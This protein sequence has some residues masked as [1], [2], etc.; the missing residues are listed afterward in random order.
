[1]LSSPLAIFFS[2]FPYD[3]YINTHEF[4]SHDTCLFCPSFVLVDNDFWVVP[5]T[6]KASE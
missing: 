1:M 3:Y 4:K 6:I 2:D 5:Y